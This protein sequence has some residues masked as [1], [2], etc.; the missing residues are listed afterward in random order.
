MPV[1]PSRPLLPSVAERT[2]GT[3]DPALEESTA[4]SRGGEKAEP[5]PLDDALVPA[6][7]FPLSADMAVRVLFGP[8]RE[9]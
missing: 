6:A 4:A 3:L 2:G 7:L 1:R 5:Q 8:L 9:T